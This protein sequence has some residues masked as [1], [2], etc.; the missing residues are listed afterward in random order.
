MWRCTKRE[1]MPIAVLLWVL[2]IHMLLLATSRPVVRSVKLALAG[3]PTGAPPLRIALLSDIHTAAPTDTPARLAAI[4]AQVN[5]L[6]PDLILLAG[7]FLG[8]GQI[9]TRHYS[10]EQ[11]IAPLSGLHAPMGVLAVPGNHDRFDHLL[12]RVD[13]ALARAGIPLLINRVVRRG[14][15]AIL[16]LDD[17]GTGHRDI[18]GMLSQWHR[19]GGVAVAVTHDPFMLNFLPKGDVG[20]RLAGHTH[21]GQISPPFYGPL[22][23]GT[24]AGMRYV[25]GVVRDFGR[26]TIV[27]AGVGTSILPMRLGAS[28]DLWL[29]ELGPAQPSS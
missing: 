4:V 15:L 7:D 28:P 11:S 25:C 26:A 21:C 1:L 6:R 5:G 2:A 29:V 27:T 19:Q 18:P 16:G 9:V 13:A 17:Y 12:G 8:T 20:V 22:K 23:A 10:V 14:P 24:D 3:W